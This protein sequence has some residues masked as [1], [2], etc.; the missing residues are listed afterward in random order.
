MTED[1]IINEGEGVLRVGWGQK[2]A[3]QQATLD[4]LG[5]AISPW[6]Y[7]PQDRA[8]FHEG[9]LRVGYGQMLIKREAEKR[10]QAK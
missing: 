9:R 6:R 8:A 3:I 2:A 7:R 1:L 10:E 4:A 5:P